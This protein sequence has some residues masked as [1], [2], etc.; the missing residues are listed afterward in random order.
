MSRRPWACE[1][2]AGQLTHHY[3]EWA[4]TGDLR[5][6]LSS[7]PE[8]VT[9]CLVRTAHSQIDDHRQWPTISR[10]HLWETDHSA[11]FGDWRI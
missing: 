1:D 5:L 10:L 11:L 3:G 8:C 2:A 6:A 4:C 9:I 7:K